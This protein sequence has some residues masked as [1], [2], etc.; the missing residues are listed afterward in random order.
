MFETTGGGTPRASESVVREVSLQHPLKRLDLLD[1]PIEGVEGEETTIEGFR[2]VEAG[3]EDKAV[4]KE[5]DA[6]VDG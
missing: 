3:D 5:A 2:E 4:S 6:G 1:S